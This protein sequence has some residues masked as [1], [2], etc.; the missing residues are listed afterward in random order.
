MFISTLVLC[1]FRLCAYKL[2]SAYVACPFS[3]Y[4]YVTIILWSICAVSLFISMCCR[5]PAWW[6]GHWPYFL[7]TSSGWTRIFQCKEVLCSTVLQ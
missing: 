4:V 1:A 3:L 6:W 2:D 5:L 7:R